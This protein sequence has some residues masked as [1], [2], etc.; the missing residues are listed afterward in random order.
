MKKQFFILFAML[1]ASI[2]GIAQT[3][4]STDGNFNAT[5]ADGNLILRTTTSSTLTQR[6][7]ILGAPGATAGFVGI[8]TATPAD[9]LHINGNA[10]ANQLNLV[11]GVLNT[12]S[13]TTNMSFSINGT[14]RM[15]LL[16]GGNFGVGTASP[17]D[18][19]HVNGTARANQLNLVG[20][21]LNTTSGTTN[22]NFNI[23]GTNRM[24]LQATTGALGIGVTPV[25]GELLH[26]NG[27]ARAT[28]FSA[29]NGT[30]NTIGATTN[31]LLNTNG[32]NRI[33][34]LANNGFVGINTLTPT[35]ALHVVGSPTIVDGNQAAG[36]VLTSD[37]NGFASWQT[38]SAGGN[39]LMGGGIS[40]L[41]ANTTI[42]GLSHEFA[43]NPV[44]KFSIQADAGNSNGFVN[45]DIATFT[46][47]P[48][49]YTN[50]FF[51]F[52]A[53]G[54]AQTEAKLRFSRSG[55]SLFNNA[56]YGG[57]SPFEVRQGA[58]QLIGDLVLRAPNG[59]GALTT[60]KVPGLFNHPSNPAV[61]NIPEMDNTNPINDTF[62]LLG[63]V[64]TFDGKKTFS[65][66]ASNAG[67]N[68]GSFTSDPTSAINGDMYYNSATNKFRAYENGVWVNSIGTGQAAVLGG[69][70]QVPFVNAT[71]NGYIGS[72]GLIFLA[73][74]NQ[75]ITGNSNAAP[76][77]SNTFTS[78]D[79]NVN[80]GLYGSAMFGELSEIDVNV[81]AAIAGGEGVYIGAYGGHSMGR[82][83][84]IRGGAFYSYIG[85]WWEP[86][87]TIGK[88]NLKVPQVSGTSSFGYYSTDPSQVDNHG[89]RANSSAILGGKNSDIPPGSHYSVVLGGLGIK[90]R[91]NDP[92][93]VYVPN[94]NIVTA[95]A[96]N[97]AL[98]QVVV[99]DGTTGQ[100]KSRDASTLSQWVTSSSGINYPVGAVG[101]GTPLTNNPNGYT[102]AV[103]GKIGA[104]DVQVETASTTWPDYVFAKDYRLPSLTEVEK[105]IQ[106][107]S[108]LENV[109]SAKEIEKNGH[110][111]GEMD[112]ILLKKLE[113][114]TLY[115]IQQQKEIDELKK[116]IEKKN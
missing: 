27:S 79:Q 67:I 37:A 59:R 105:Y 52:V 89:V 50:P 48:T 17:S 24:Q 36:K 109:P 51:E 47:D 81:G 56:F 91:D 1:L 44:R 42:S 45:S 83:T 57:I 22:M 5:N 34:I 68:L 112:K 69:V 2:T 12:A 40:N 82:G 10:R 115:V 3:V 94:L 87:T 49:D 39:V 38:P 30:F 75:F 60:V 71:N 73:A 15:T 110:S 100:L 20:G 16:S 93:Q 25:A 9:L 64:Q 92:Q 98:T 103:N 96:V 86:N 13:G 65:A 43:I 63:Q 101:I 35:S 53:L 113:E 85:G 14:T 90:A 72:A 6:L 55:L 32:T 84:A 88:T 114:L 46:M 31:F 11:N 19:L 4:N 116:K 33:T 58:I 28:Q 106:E 99:R 77:G 7:T 104:K 26:V 107:N 23:N 41:N 70:G 80:K 102:L 62:T 66:K 97:N 29:T 95:P 76:A 78:G 61:I 21:T 111:L 108:H 54:S 8:G 18:L 74:S